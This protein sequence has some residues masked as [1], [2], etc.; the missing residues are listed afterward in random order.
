MKVLLDAKETMN[1][2][3]VKIYKMTERMNN[4]F[5]KLLFILSVIFHM[6]FK[7]NIEINLYTI[8]VVYEYIKIS[9]STFLVILT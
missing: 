4:Y 6:N 8:T 3:F 5:T 7:M 2:F 9:L 1:K